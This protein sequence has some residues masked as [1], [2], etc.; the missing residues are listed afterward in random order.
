MILIIDRCACS[1]CVAIFCFLM[2][3]RPPSATRTAHS[4]PI[5]RSSDLLWLGS[6]ARHAGSAAERLLELGFGMATSWDGRW[7]VPEYHPQNLG[8]LNGI[9]RSEEHTSE[10]QPLMRI[11]Y[12][13]FCLKKTNTQ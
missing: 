13:V 12:A 5:R 6:G 10:L 1:N 4:F 7:M 2:L 8:G 11:S 3:R 9:G